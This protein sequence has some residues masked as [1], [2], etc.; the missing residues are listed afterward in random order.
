MAMT[1][2]RLLTLGMTVIKVTY[3]GHDGDPPGVYGA[4]HTVLEQCHQESLGG[5]LQQMF[6]SS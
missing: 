5:F 3:L 4:Q 1:L 2:L 6:A